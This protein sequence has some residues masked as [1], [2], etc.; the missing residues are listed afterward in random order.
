VVSDGSETEQGVRFEGRTAEL[1]VGARKGW[2]LERFRPWVAAGGA[3]IAA[4]VEASGA[5]ESGLDSDDTFGWW[6]GT[7]VNFPTAGSFQLGLQLRYSSADVNLGG[8]D[9]KAGG[10]AGL[11]VFGWI[12]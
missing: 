3:W 11:V 7:G 5:G 4:R 12:R 2:E 8:V 10:F 6:A 9:G 1:S